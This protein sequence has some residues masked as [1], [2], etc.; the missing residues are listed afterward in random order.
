MMQCFLFYDSENLGDLFGKFVTIIQI[1]SFYFVITYLC[2]KKK[3][4]IYDN[5]LCNSH[6][7]PMPTIYPLNYSRI[8]L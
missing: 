4:Q 7:G 3:K 5:S 6:A 1:F 2:F 8:R